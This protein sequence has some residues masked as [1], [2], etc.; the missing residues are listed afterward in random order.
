M[1]TGII[2]VTLLSDQNKTIIYSAFSPL[3]TCFFEGE[4]RDTEFAGYS[5]FR[6]SSP[7]ENRILAIR[8][9]LRCG[10]KLDICL[11]IRQFCFTYIKLLQYNGCSLYE[12]L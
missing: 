2:I 6:I 8:L 12:Q 5:A 10:G 11:D 7:Y 9:D 1:F 4:A 3:L